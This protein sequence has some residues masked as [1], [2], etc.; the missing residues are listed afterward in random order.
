MSDRI[1]ELFVI[2]LQ[3]VD[4]RQ[5]RVN[6]E[7]QPKFSVCKSMTGIKLE[8]AFSVIAKKKKIFTPKLYKSSKAKNNALFEFF[9]STCAQSL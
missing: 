8:T 2:L 9:A 7:I 5:E 4:D 6:S 3:I 1:T